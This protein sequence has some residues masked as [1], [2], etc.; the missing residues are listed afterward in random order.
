MNPRVAGITIDPSFFRQSV[1]LEFLKF[2]LG[3]LGSIVEQYMNVR[4]QVVEA[5]FAPMVLLRAIGK[6]WLISFY[7]LH[8]TF[9]LTV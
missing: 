5:R 8:T 6:V 1:I 2:L 9:S 3:Y 7:P 4:I